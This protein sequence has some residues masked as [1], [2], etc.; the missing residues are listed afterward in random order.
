M[1]DTMQLIIH[2]LE[3]ALWVDGKGIVSIEPEDASPVDQTE[4]ASGEWSA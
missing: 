2:A 3:V 4:E 1:T